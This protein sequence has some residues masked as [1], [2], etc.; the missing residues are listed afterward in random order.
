MVPIGRLG[1]GAGLAAFALLILARGA[2][3]DEPQR[4]NCPD[5][6]DWIRMSGTACVQARSTLPANGKIGYDGH[7]LC[8]DPF[9][10]IYESRPTSD[11]KP[12]PGAPYTSFAYLLECV[13]QQEFDARQARAAEAAQ[14]GD[15][16]RLLADSGRSLPPGE[17]VLLGA[18]GS[19]A[20]IFAALPTLRRR[21]GVAG[22]PPAEEPVESEATTGD[23]VAAR[24]DQLELRAAELDKIDQRLAEQVRTIRDKAR[25]NQLSILDV[26]KWAGIV[27]D[28]LGVLPIPQTQIPA[29]LV[30]GFANLSGIAV[31]ALELDPTEVYRQAREGLGDIARLRGIIASERDGIGAA[32]QALAAQATTPPAVPPADPAVLPDTTLREERDRA[33]AEVMRLHDGIRQTTDESV[34]LRGLRSSEDDRSMALRNALRGLDDTPDLEIPRDANTAVNITSGLDGAVRMS[35]GQAL[36]GPLAEANRALDSTFRSGSWSAHL[37][38]RTSHAGIAG[39]IG[40]LDQAGRSAS[41]AG[42]GTAAL[43]ALDWWG[44]RSSEEARVLIE[45]SIEG[46]QYLAGRLDQDARAAEARVE[47]LRHEAQQA[48]ARRRAL[49]AEIDMRTARSGHLLWP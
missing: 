14:M 1:A 25:A 17:L 15:A 22:P 35:Q 29:A 5:G 7:A 39:E 42:A 26:V 23:E 20:L 2:V 9:V 38:A 34:R 47:E 28:M 24:I 18:L 11:G 12:P 48:A 8:I 37:Q 27:S 31:D 49:S 21:P 19:G 43:S 16:S 13:T 3:A 4:Y 40:N 30:S 46:H 6:F 44:A 45:Q 36:E 33:Q 10:S 32:L 41:V